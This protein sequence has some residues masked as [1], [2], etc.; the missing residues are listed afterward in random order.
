VI[1]LLICSFSNLNQLKSKK[2]LDKLTCL[3]DLD[4]F[5]LNTD[6]ANNSDVNELVNN[7]KKLINNSGAKHKEK[8]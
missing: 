5:S 6:L 2:D 8:S 4:L 7:L 1:W 3:Y